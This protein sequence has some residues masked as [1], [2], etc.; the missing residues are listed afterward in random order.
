MRYYSGFGVAALVDSATSLETSPLHADPVVIICDILMTVQ[1]VPGI[2]GR[3]DWRRVAYLTLGT[4]PGVPLGVA[5]LSGI[6]TDM[7]RA[8][9]S[10]THLTL[11]TI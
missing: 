6:G 10:Y 4:L 9:V 2:W 1:Q 5:V 3:I 8:A 7:A 11:L